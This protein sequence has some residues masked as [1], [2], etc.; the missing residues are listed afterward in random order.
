MLNG[1]AL[2]YMLSIRCALMVKVKEGQQLFMGN[3]SALM[4]QGI[5]NIVETWEDDI[6][7]RA[8]SQQRTFHVPNNI[9]RVSFKSL[10]IW[11]YRSLVSIKKSSIIVK[12]AFKLDLINLYQSEHRLVEDQNKRTT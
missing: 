9:I 7:E 8:C 2:L 4:V 6:W 11:I 1:K 12:E 5:G 3:A 10:S